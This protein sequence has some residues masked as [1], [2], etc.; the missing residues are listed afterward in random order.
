ML[1][2]NAD[3]LHTYFCHGRASEQQGLL[4]QFFGQRRC[5]MM[6]TKHSELSQF[7]GHTIALP[8]CQACTCVL[9]QSPTRN[10]PK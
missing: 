4:Q 9:A 6:K 2:I 8:M 5:A 10:A 3:V 1:L 7:R